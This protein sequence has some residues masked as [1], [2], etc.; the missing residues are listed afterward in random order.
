MLQMHWAFVLRPGSE[1]LSEPHVGDVDCEFPR[2]LSNM[3]MWTFAIEPIEQHRYRCMTL[4][5]LE[6]LSLA[7]G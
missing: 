6:S 1:C 3:V 4:S 7:A 2:K 5:V